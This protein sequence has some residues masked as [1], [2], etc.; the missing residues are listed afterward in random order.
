MKAD[1]YVSRRLLV[2]A[3]SSKLKVRFTYVKNKVITGAK[4]WTPD[5]SPT[6]L[7]RCI[8][9]LRR[10]RNVP[11]WT[12]ASMFR[13]KHAMTASRLPSTMAYIALSISLQAY[14]LTHF[15]CIVAAVPRTV[16]EVRN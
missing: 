13:S 11:A 14:C 3:M 2:S 9:V 8:E 1:R 10:S 7:C 6:S 15:L 12:Q 4:T 5:V 16:S